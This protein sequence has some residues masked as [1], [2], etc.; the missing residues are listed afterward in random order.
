MGANYIQITTMMFDFFQLCIMW[1][2]PLD[3]TSIVCLNNARA[4]QASNSQ[5][6]TYLCLPSAGIKGVRHHHPAKVQ[7]FKFVHIL[8]FISFKALKEFFTLPFVSHFKVEFG[9]LP[10]DYSMN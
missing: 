7:H 10:F 1:N 4:T 2:V 5:R 9:L 8:I 6:S 3:N